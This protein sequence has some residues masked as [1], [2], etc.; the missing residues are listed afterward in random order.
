VTSAVLSAVGHRVRVVDSGA[1]ALARLR[2]RPADL[3]VLDLDMPGMDGWEVLRRV[4]ADPRLA[5]MPVI[6]YSANSQPLPS[7]APAP[8]ASSP[9][10]PQSPNS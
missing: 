10:A 6:V 3:M 1:A 7:G 2:E 9:R 5:A 4:R 8:I